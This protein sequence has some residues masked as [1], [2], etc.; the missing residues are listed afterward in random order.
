MNSDSLTLLEAELVPDEFEDPIH[1]QALSIQ[2]YEYAYELYMSGEVDFMVPLQTVEDRYGRSLA[3]R[4]DLVAILT[5]ELQ[6]LKMRNFRLSWM[7]KRRSW[8]AKTQNMND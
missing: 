4:N 7:R 3:R 8:L 1:H 2:Y 5:G 6:R